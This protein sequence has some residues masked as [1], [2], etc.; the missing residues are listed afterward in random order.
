MHS[1]HIKVPRRHTE[2]VAVLLRTTVSIEQISPS[3]AATGHLK[4]QSFSEKASRGRRGRR[5]LSATNP[6]NTNLADARLIGTLAA[7]MQVVDTAKAVWRPCQTKG[8]RCGGQLWRRVP[9]CATLGGSSSSCRG[10][11]NWSS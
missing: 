10:G 5:F 9:A 4:I 8:G 3:K 7:S 1:T 6:S 2:G 11:S